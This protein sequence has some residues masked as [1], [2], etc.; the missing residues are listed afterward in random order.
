MVYKRLQMDLQLT[1]HNASDMLSPVDQS[2]DQ[3]HGHARHGH[4]A[5]LADGLDFVN[6]LEFRKGEPHEELTDPA[7][8]ISWLQE[9]E[10]LHR[11]AAE[12]C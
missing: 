12:H 8:A 11:G 7:T 3:D 1:S 4:L 9:H 6:T 5:S 2:H 10:L